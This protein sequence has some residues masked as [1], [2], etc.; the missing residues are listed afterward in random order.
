MSNER[1][2]DKLVVLLSLDAKPYKKTEKEIGD[3]TKKTAETIEKGASKGDANDKKRDRERTKRERT[4]AARRRKDAQE[5]QRR[6][7]ELNDQLVG[8]GRT[9]A[10]M[11]LGFETLKGAATLFN[12]YV[13]NTAAMGRSAE[14]L[15]VGVHEFQTFGAAIK[16]AG[17]DAE[18]AKA[19]FAS[20]QQSIFAATTRGERSPFI[21][22]LATMGVYLR[23]SK[24]NVKDLTALLNELAD[25]MQKRGL[26]RA[27]AFQFL[28]GAGVGEDV[29]NLLLAKN[30]QELLNKAAATS[31]INQNQVDRATQLQLKR[32]NLKNNIGGFGNEVGAAITSLLLG[33]F[34]TYVDEGLSPAAKGAKHTGSMFLPALDEIGKKH[35]LP[36]GLLSAVAFQ[37]SSLNPDAVNKKSGAAGIMQLRPSIFPG[38]GHDPIKD[39]E[40]AATELERLFKVFGTWEAALAAYNDGQGNI[41]S[42]L[43]TGKRR[44]G[45]SGLPEETT[46]YISNILGPTPAAGGSTANNTNSVVTGPVTIQTNANSISG[47]AEDFSEMLR[48]KQDVA[49][50]NGG[51]Y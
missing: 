6:N 35:G 42:L 4:D 15:G 37:E 38:A 25:A 11:F 1:L 39:M 29:A 3:V 14:N 30:R 49:Q 5:Q 23:D 36:S 9:A 48:R 24:G 17:G 34:K 28:Q 33:K 43:K 22:T 13:T 7:V 47:A 16:L 51:M 10:G 27:Q 50:A 41:E 46:K 18:A 44:N 12:S 20:M 31:G 26:N 40:V 45:E 19:Q 2:I 32:D 8:L 21:Q